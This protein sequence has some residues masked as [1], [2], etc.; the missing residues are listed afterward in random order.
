MPW[1]QSSLGLTEDSRTIDSGCNHHHIIIITV[2]ILRPLLTSLAQQKNT[3]NAC[4]ATLL[5]T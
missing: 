1:L 2:N 3:Q 5:P 4:N